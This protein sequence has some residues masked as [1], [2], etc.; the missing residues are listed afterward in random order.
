M[1]VPASVVDSA[2]EAARP[3]IDAKKQ[4]FE[5]R[6]S[7]APLYVD[8]DP[9]RLAQVISNL[10]NNASKFT[11]LGGRIE[12]AL[13]ADASDAI[14]SI[15]DTGVG[16]PAAENRRIF[17]MFVQLDSA[18]G[19]AGGGLGIGLTLVRSLVEM[20]GGR[21][22]AHSAGAGAGA[23]FTVRLPLA[24]AM[25]WAGEATPG[26]PTTAIAQRVLVVDD[27]ADATA[28]LAQI[29]AMAGHDVRGALDPA[30]ALRLAPAFEPQVAFLDIDMPGMNGYQLAAALRALPWASDLRLIAVT[31]MGQPSDREAARAAGFNAHLTKPAAP[32]EVLRLASEPPKAAFNLHSERAVEV[33]TVATAGRPADEETADGSR[34][35]TA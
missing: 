34:G 1:L 20:H 27:N 6:G 22:D 17:D 28:S 33:L 10:L 32:E 8:G 35:R 19:D 24:V 31:G 30:E 21:I 25:P 16:F 4:S 2:V 7:P 18:R 12:L 11:P 26:A 5:L 14:V 9:V 23:T 15:Q 3:A 13:A 29:L